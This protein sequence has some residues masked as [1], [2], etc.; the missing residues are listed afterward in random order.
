MILGTGEHHP[1]SLGKSCFHPVDEVLPS[2]GCFSAGPDHGH[3]DPV[4]DIPGPDLEPEGNPPH[5]PVVVFRTRPHVPVIDLDPVPGSRQFCPDGS[6]SLPDLGL[7]LLHDHRHDDY[8][9][10]GDIRWQNEAAVIPVHADQGGDGP[11]R[12]PVTGLVTVFLLP[13]HVLVRDTERLR[14]MIAEVVNRSDLEGSAIGHDRIDRDRIVGTRELVPVRPLR[15][16]HRDIKPIVELPVQGYC[17]LD[18]RLGILP[19]RMDG[20]GFLERSD[21]PEPDQGTGMLCLIPERVHN[22]VELEGEIGMGSYPEGIHRIYC[23]LACRPEGKFH[24][25]GTGPPV[26]HPVDLLFKSLDVF[27]L[28]HELM[29]GDEER[30]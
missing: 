16:Q 20:M 14:E 10:R 26:G 7:P 12:D 30:K 21:L 25:Q 29:L 2:D 9:N 15:D 19:G 11:L 24:I 28:F 3:H 13:L 27:G 5:L 8:L 1:G 6:S 4:I 22:L 23:R 17:V 18:R